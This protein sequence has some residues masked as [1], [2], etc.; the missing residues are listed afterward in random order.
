[1]EG[2]TW[3]DGGGAVSEDAVATRDPILESVKRGVVDA[4]AYEICLIIIVSPDVGV[5]DEAT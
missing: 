3:E 4:D 1:M 2:R 5:E